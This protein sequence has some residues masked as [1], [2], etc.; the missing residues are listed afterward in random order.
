M[1]RTAPI[2][3]LENSEEWE[4]LPVTTT[5]R[6]RRA[7]A[8]SALPDLAPLP[9]EYLADGKAAV[10]Q[11]T[12]AVA[13]QPAAARAR[14]AGAGFSAIDLRVDTPLDE[15]CIVVARHASG[16][17]TFH[18][19]ETALVR[20]GRR[21]AGVLHFHIP[22]RPTAP[23]AVRRGVVA[24]AVAGVVRIFVVKVVD[25]LLDQH[26]LP[27]LAGRWE[28]RAWRGSARPLDWLRVDP[29][30]PGFVRAWQPDA[31]TLR[32]GPCLLLIHGTFSDAR[33]GFVKLV[34]T[35]FFAR[36][37][38]RY[39]DRIFAFNHFTVSQT[40][41]QNAQRLLDLLPGGDWTFDVV[42]HSRGGLVLR[43]LVERA[44]A[45]EPGQRGGRF[46]VG[47]V[48]LVASPNEG[49]PLATPDRWEKT[50]GWFANLMEVF[51][52]NPWT[53]GA[54][55]IAEAIVWLARHAAEGLPGIG[56]MN[57]RGETIAALQDPPSPPPDAY[58]ALVANYKP[59]ERLWRRLLDVG[60][61]GFFGTAND[62]VVPTEGGWCVTRDGNPGVPPER[63]GCFGVGGNLLPES[64]GAVQ[65]GTFFERPETAKFIA[66]ALLGRAHELRPMDIERSL[67]RRSAG[68]VASPEP[69]SVPAPTPLPV[70][71]GD[72][73]F[74]VGDMVARH[75][76]LRLT[77]LAP[78]AEAG[79]AKQN[80]VQILATYGN[81]TELEIFRLGGKED[82][83]GR[84]MQQIITT[85]ERIRDYVDGDEG[86]TLPG[87]QE[88][89]EFGELL[90]E[91]LFPGN[92]RRLYDV[93]RSMVQGG[94]R[95]DIIFTS[96]IPWIADKPWEF[97]YDPARRTFLS[98]EEIHFIRNV[99][100]SV[101]AAACEA[102]PGPLRILVAAAQPVGAGTLSLEEEVRVIERGF[103]ALRAA[104]LAQ[105]KV[106]AR[107]TP[108][109]LHA[110]LMRGDYDLFH[111][112]GHGE[113]VD[114]RGYLLF[115][116]SGG[117]VH[118]VNERSMREILL[119]R[120][121]RLVFLNACETGRGGAA[122]ST[123]GVAQAL[124]AGG[125]PA[126]VANQYKVLDQSATVF[127]QHFYWSLARGKSIA[128]AA[129]E[130]RIAVN[131]SYGDAIDWAVPVVY[132]RDP[133][134]RLCGM[135]DK[136]PAVTAA[137]L[138]TV[139]A[140]ARQKRRGPDSARRI[141]MWDMVHAF[142]ELEELLIAWNGA[143]SHFVF[144]VTDLTAPVGAWQV[145]KDNRPR[146]NSDVLARRLANIPMQLGVDYVIGL[147]DHVMRGSG[148][149]GEEWDGIFAWWWS[150]PLKPRTGDTPT[151][152]MFVSVAELELPAGD[153]ASRGKQIQ[154]LIT[155]AMVMCLAGYITKHDSH[156][157]GPQRCPLYRNPKRSVELLTAHQSF[158]AGCRRELEKA[159]P[160]AFAALERLLACLQP[161]AK[162]AKPRKRAEP[163]PK[164]ARSRRVRAR[165]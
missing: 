47:R 14:R 115:E 113:F 46:A 130:S 38:P 108:A 153:P 72:R 32:A 112:I 114:G 142:P 87:D 96:Q 116:D 117:G 118:R 51:P 128:A 84:R 68:G 154:R 95:L 103:E 50:L 75:E 143:Q 133:H 28:E 164:K 137:V 19:P 40:P 136:A 119:S 92:T 4:L 77:I 8:T 26:L 25:R 59:D 41:Q 107:A 111:F 80:V 13:R 49:T 83:A 163:G 70:V 61:D 165:A 141:A 89:L 36:V 35:D 120:G 109:E 78:P 132:A 9:P 5:G 54:S 162:P 82:A 15:P 31:A 150:P 22:V 69:R 123:R 121:I 125:M 65:H 43:Q 18:P 127:A 73:S 152:I 140:I 94:D 88:M 64:S 129:R 147:T 16:A 48:V 10:V 101:P 138:P 124:V 148:E 98:T 42:T 105:V 3:M 55:W 122:D 71:P 66:D 100:T 158:D 156:E 21:T 93:A 139:A 144:E 7:A 17:L 81:A 146:L 145:T 34:G 60:I 126:V 37:A 30:A 135:L 151:R 149:T 97:S 79:A 23:V 1:P 27:Y 85:H 33:G 90:F 2:I 57:G 12:I 29:G 44:D 74:M 63:V 6:R 160:A 56:A 104:S 20:R 62:L 102:R 24:N 76:P 159:D 110:E 161:P 45:L 52:D 53:V 67:P 157:R 106:L 134:A 11:D 155:N 86:A 91:T 58:S 39:G 131:Y 99:F